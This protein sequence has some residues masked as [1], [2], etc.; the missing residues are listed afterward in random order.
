METQ[1]YI[2]TRRA[3]FDDCKGL[4]SLVENTG[5]AAIYKASFGQFNFP[6]VIEN[7]FLSIVVTEGFHTSE[8]IQEENYVGFMC[9]NDTCSVNGD[10]DSFSD[11]IGYL[12]NYLPVHVRY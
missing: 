7:S 10:I 6:S 3:D 12:K 5:G 2:T 1:S 8:T 9:V 11:T 4:N